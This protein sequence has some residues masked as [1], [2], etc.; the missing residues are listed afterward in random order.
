M[1]DERRILVALGGS[2]ADHGLA[3]YAAAVAGLGRR[4]GRL[5]ETTA[6]GGPHDQAMPYPDAGLTAVP[7]APAAT[8]QGH[9]VVLTAPAALRFLPPGADVAEA[10]LADGAEVV[11]VGEGHGGAGR[12]LAGRLV[13]QASASVWFV[14]DDAPPAF[15]RILVPVDYSIRAADS[16][17]V[18]STL[19]RL[20]GAD[21]CLALHVWFNSCV[22]ETPGEDRRARERWAAAHARFMSRID[23]LAVPVSPLFREGADVARTVARVAEEEGADLIVM[24][25]RGRTRAAG[26]LT[27]SAAGRVLRDTRVPLLVVKHFGARL[28]MLRALFEKL[29]LRGEETRFS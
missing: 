13:R 7:A 18:A 16:L 15:R 26:L 28:G 11:L 19:G 4:A 8:D 22:I 23:T 25:S 14:P 9:A 24:A 21:E 3:R 20:T 12:S 17:R 27:E 2:D 6:P 29:F 10:A 1:N 5:P